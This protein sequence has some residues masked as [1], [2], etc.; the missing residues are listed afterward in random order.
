MNSVAATRR[1]DRCVAGPLAVGEKVKISR[2]ALAGLV[3]RIHAFIRRERCLLTIDGVSE[4]VKIAIG[5][6]AIVRAWAADCEDAQTGSPF[7]AISA[8]RDLFQIE[9]GPD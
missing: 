4:A 7:R 6:D 5:R 8:G 3:G 9:R 1:F 2:G